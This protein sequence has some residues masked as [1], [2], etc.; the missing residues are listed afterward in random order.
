MNDFTHVFQSEIECTDKM[1]FRK[2]TYV[3]SPLFFHSDMDVFF[4]DGVRIYLTDEESSFQKIR[5]R[6]AGIEM[7]G[8]PALLNFVHCKNVHIHGKAILYGNGERWY[9]KYWGFDTKGGM[10]KTYDEKGLRWACDYDCFRPKMIL[11]QNSS[12]IHLSDLELHDSPFWNVHVLYSRNVFLDHLK[13]FSE[14]PNSPSTDGIDIDSSEDVSIS[15]CYISTNDDGVSIKSG[16]DGDGIRVNRP[17]RNVVIQDCEFHHGYG[18]SVGSE[19]SGGVENICGKN[20]HFISSDCGFRIKSSSTRKGYVRNICLDGL[21]MDGVKYPIYCYLDWNRSYN[22]NKLP[23][24]YDGKIPDYWYTLLNLPSDAIKNT[25]VDGISIKNMKLSC[26]GHDSCLFTICGFADSPIGNLCFSDFTGDVDE[27]GSFENCECPAFR[28]VNVE[29]S[30]N[31][32]T[33]PGS[34]DNR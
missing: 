13:I 29:V 16:R 25:Y 10:R 28:N 12:D 1:V 22:L 26:K 5:T 7:D 31:I 18:L 6:I 3:C 20:L 30:G 27:Y 11:I 23:E 9:E 17:T 24:G 4:E 14:N 21:I 34:F 2:G 15:S 32:H 8:Y 33:I 19:L